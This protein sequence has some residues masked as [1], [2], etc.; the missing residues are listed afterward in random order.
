MKF[1]VE[2]KKLKKAIQKVFKAVSKKTSMPI[3][4]NILVIAEE[5]KV[6]LAA[7]DLKAAIRTEIEEVKIEKEGKTLLEG[8]FF[9]NVIKE[10]PK[11][12][13]SVKKNRVNTKIFTDKNQINIKNEKVEEFPEVFDNSFEENFKFEIAENVLLDGLNKVKYSMDKDQGRLRLEGV[14][15]TIDEKDGEKEMKL[16]STDTYRLSVFDT[17]N[18]YVLEEGDC[19][20]GIETIIP[21]EAVKKLTSL[22]NSKESKRV[23]ITLD[24]SRLKLKNDELELTT[25]VIDDQFPDYERIL[26]TGSK[27]EFE[28]EYKKIY[29]ALRK[30]KIL[31][32]PDN[33]GVEIK[34]NE[35]GLLEFKSLLPE[36]GSSTQKV[37]VDYTG[38]EFSMYMN[39]EYLLQ[40][41]KVAKDKMIKFKTEDSLSPLKVIGKNYENVNMPLRSM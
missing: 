15:L 19:K 2:N 20:E 24:D 1:T 35:N 17:K 31:T 28:V 36:V 30:A 10:M 6:K 16:V 29:Q 14:L 32:S 39:I 4:E 18:Y 27:V 11:G 13:I 8:S 9:K 25:Q 26:D 40:G 41:V 37:D 12:E 34:V 21:R 5:E 23:E 3:L 22:L 7:T 33:R 38:K